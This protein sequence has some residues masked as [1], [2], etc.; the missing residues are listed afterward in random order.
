MNNKAQILISVFLLLLMIS[1]FSGTLARLWPQEIL[2]RRYENKGLV[3]FYLAQAGIERA[4]IE[5][6]RNPGLWGW[7]FCQDDLNLSCWYNDVPGGLYKFHIATLGG[8][9]REIISRGVV[10]DPSNRTLAQRELE[11]TI[12]IGTRIQESWSWR[13]R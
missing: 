6:A 10:R 12:D 11:A 4:K 8:N 3:A 7:Q 1:I 13:E 9:R 2:T 5:A